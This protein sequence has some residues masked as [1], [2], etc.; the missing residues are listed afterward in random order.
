MVVGPWDFTVTMIF[1]TGNAMM[2]P[3]FVAYD[4]NFP[5]VPG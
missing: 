2:H 3:E 4:P 5:T 1:E